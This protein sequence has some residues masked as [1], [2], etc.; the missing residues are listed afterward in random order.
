MEVRLTSLEGWG[1][2]GKR[3]FDIVGSIFLILVF[4]PLLSE[5]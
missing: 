5:S 1:A 2:V 3:V 4:S